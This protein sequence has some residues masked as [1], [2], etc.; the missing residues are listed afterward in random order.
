MRLVGKGRAIGGGLR[1]E[2]RVRIT[3]ERYFKVEL[4]CELT[5]NAGLLPI[6]S[7]CVVIA[8]QRSIVA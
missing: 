1:G 3:S 4:K 2:V 8:E 7:C 5:T 6:S